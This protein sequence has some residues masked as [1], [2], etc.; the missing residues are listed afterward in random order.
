MYLEGIKFS[1]FDPDGHSWMNNFAIIHLHRTSFKQ[2]S[3]ID[4]YSCATP[5]SI[6]I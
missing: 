4:K 3:F 6:K 1:E 5:I 2:L